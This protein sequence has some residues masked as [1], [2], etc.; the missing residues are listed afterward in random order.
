MNINPTKQVIR[1]GYANVD[2]DD[3]QDLSLENQIEL[4]EKESCIFIYSEKT[5]E[6]NEVRS[7]LLK[8]LR[9]VRHL[10]EKRTNEIYLIVVKND[11]ISIKIRT[12]I[13]MIDDLSELGIHYISLED[14][15]DTSTTG[16][17]MIF[18]ILSS[19]NNYEVVNNSEKVKIGLEK[20][21]KDGKKLGCPKIPP[22]VQSE[23]LHL[24]QSNNY[25][26]KMIAE[27]YNISTKSIYNIIKQFGIPHRRGNYH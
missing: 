14:H 20:A 17:R 6:G 26:V 12:V 13:N 5:S 18:Q 25:S 1:I 4:L 9:H 24:Y 10:A 23:V 27:K 3:K 8:A 2:K 21:K 19:F 11:C 15:I 16:D 7:E 22:E